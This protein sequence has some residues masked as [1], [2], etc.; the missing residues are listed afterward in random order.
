MIILTFLLYFFYRVF[1]FEFKNRQYL[2]T[3]T[4]IFLQF[5][6]MASYAYT[7]IELIEN[8]RKNYCNLHTILHVANT[9]ILFLKRN[10]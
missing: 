7:R 8:T 3:Q 4:F 5:N 1:L 2:Y 6:I 9:F 10:T